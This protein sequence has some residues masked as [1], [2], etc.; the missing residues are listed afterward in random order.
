MA[1]TTR[2]PRRSGRPSAPSPDGG[3][4]RT[5]FIGTGSFGIDALRR[6]AVSQDVALVGL[7]TAPPRPA[8][9]GAKVRE[10][11]IAS[12]NRDGIGIVPVLAPGRLRA[13]AAI[14]E[15]LAL[16]PALIVLV[17][18]GQIVPAALLELPLGAL[19]L[20]PSL[21]PRHRGA[22]PIPATILAG[23]A[24]TGVS[25]MR[26]DA[27]LD[28]G[29]I[30]EIDEMDLDG[31]ETTPMLEVRLAAMAARL[32]VR[33]LPAWI[34]GD[35]RPRAQSADGAT[36]T[37]PL[38]RSDG[39]LDPTKRADRLER[40]VR[41]YQPWPG[42][43]FESDAGRFTVWRARPLAREAGE[44]PPPG[45]LVAA[46]GGGLGVATGDGLL[47]LLEIQIAG[48]RRMSGAELVRGRPG[49][50]GSRLHEDPAAPVG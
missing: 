49:V 4:P 25:L 33:S 10:S 15:V 8:G 6:L 7:V 50:V 12:A 17:D 38:R 16:D 2:S 43:W 20:H 14:A 18:Y 31:S 37:R 21:L 42:S 5:V 36:L 28:T 19:N 13:P 47:E 27:G 41:A 24:R 26:M 44:R 3:R 40:E 30:V 32:L 29:P 22:T 34:A 23:D 9:R 39:R 48:G 45:T 35:L 46:G 11:P 1:R